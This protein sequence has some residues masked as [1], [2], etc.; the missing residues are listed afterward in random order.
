MHEFS[1]A[2]SLINIVEDTV[3][4][5]GGGKVYKV[6]VKIGKLSGVEPYLLQTAFDFLRQ[7]SDHLK[8]AVLVINIQEIVCKCR[9]CGAEFVAS[10]F[11]VVCKVCGS[12]NTDVVDGKDMILESVTSSPH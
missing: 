10:D 5:N 4:I 3:A 6:V 7:E 12:Y 8:D 11:D 9:D 2:K 1:V